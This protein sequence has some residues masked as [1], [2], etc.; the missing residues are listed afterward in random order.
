MKR[1]LKDFP[2]DAAPHGHQT[3][4]VQQ[5]FRQR[6]C[7]TD[8]GYRPT[9]NK[10]HLE[11]LSAD[12][13]P[14]TFHSIP[15][16]G[17][18]TSNQFLMLASQQSSMNMRPAEIAWWEVQQSDGDEDR[19]LPNPR[20]NNVAHTVSPLYKIK[21][22]S[23]NYRHVKTW[24]GSSSS[25]YRP[26]QK[27]KNSPSVRTP[28]FAISNSSSII[29]RGWFVGRNWTKVTWGCSTPFRDIS[30]QTIVEFALSPVF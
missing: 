13:S 19:M 6:V 24:F 12:R 3:S 2:Q 18:E 4:S 11:L 7:E 26:H 30:D 21:N 20:I 23:G 27:L 16:R 10:S 14:R 22:A 25:W 17:N 29:L 15:V 8:S 1:R 28:Y 9:L 5:P